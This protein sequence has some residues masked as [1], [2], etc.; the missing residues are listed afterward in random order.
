MSFRLAAQE[1]MLEGDTLEEKFAFARAH[2]FDGIEL[3]GRGGGV[4]A[5]RR[6]ELAAALAAGV[7]MPSAVVAMPHFVGD[8]DEDNRR[9]AIEDVKGLLSTLPAA[10]AAGIVMPNGFAVFS[11]RLPPFEPPRSEEES[12][13]KLV[14]SLTELGRHGEQVGAKVFL[15]P[16]NRY[17]DYLINTLADA[18]SIVEEVGSSAVSVIADTFHMSIEETDLGAAIRQAGSHIEHVQL[19]DSDRLEPGHGHY[20]WPETLDALEAIGY[21]GWLAMECRLS[22]PPAEVLPRVSALLKR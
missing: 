17:E 11:T 9:A 18:V 15:E 4:F 6:E 19:G 21:D 14:E 8:F 16:L 20:D 3:S 1:S 10:G 5:A 2:G 22:G 13:A 12:R 7:V